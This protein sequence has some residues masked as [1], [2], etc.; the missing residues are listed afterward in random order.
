MKITPLQVLLG[1]GAAVGAYFLFKPKPRF[2]GDTAKVGDEVHVPVTSLPA[3]ALPAAVPPGVGFIRVKVNTVAADTLD[4][5]M[6]AWVLQETP[7]LQQVATQPIGPMRIPK[8]YVTTVY[9]GG[10]EVV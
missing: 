8:Q 6:V 2:K 4:G 1:A 10:K 5:Y 7:T 9:R 3:G